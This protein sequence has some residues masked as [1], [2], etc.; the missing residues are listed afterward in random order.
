MSERKIAPVKDNKDKRRTYAKQKARYCSAMK[1]GFY[2]EAMMIDYALLEDRLRSVLYHIG[3]LANRR[4]TSV[5]KKARPYFT[6]IVKQYKTEK[7]NDALGITNISGKIKIVRSILL[8]VANTEGGYQYNEHLVLL[9]SRFE[10]LDIDA[11]LRTI[12]EI[13]EW[14]SYR[15]EIV[16]ALMN[17]NLES[18]ESE[19]KDKAGKGMQ[20]ANILDTQER[21]IK[22]GNKIRRGINLVIEK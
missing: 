10:E 19:L 16:H 9:K 1:Y 6:E 13:E 11:F 12:K 8:W 21:I 4:S 18:I 3:F 22:K 7:E 14:C 17:K 20:L 2:L 15:N 5:W